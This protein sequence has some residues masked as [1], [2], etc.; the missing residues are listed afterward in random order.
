MVWGRSNSTTIRSI[1]RADPTR[2]SGA[3]ASIQKV[4]DWVARIF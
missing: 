1:V 2:G 4:F 3:G